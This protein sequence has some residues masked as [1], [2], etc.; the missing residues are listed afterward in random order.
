MHFILF[1]I[2]VQQLRVHLCTGSLINGKYALSSGRCMSNRD[3]D[4]LVVEYGST[5]IYPGND[6]RTNTVG[7]S[8]ILFP[9]D[10]NYTT[11]NNDIS[12]IQLASEVSLAKFYEP[13]V[14]LTSTG[15]RFSSGLHAT[16]AGNEVGNY[17]KFLLLV[18][19]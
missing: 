12:I 19:K 10:F 2:S 11:G 3:V 8:Q 17:L 16:H 6:E 4:R 18:L 9:P 1:K 15:S 13:F 5:T 14:H 7:V